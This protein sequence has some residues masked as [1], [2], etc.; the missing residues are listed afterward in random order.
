MKETELTEFLATREDLPKCFGC[1]QE[2]PIGLKLSFQWDGQTATAEFSPGELHQGWPGLVHGGIISCLLDEAMAYAT[3]FQGLTCL[4]AKMWAKLKHPVPL[5]EPLAI[6]ATMT[7]K[8]R[9]LVETKATITL[10]DGTLAVEGAATMYIL[11]HGKGGKW[12]RP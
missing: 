12:K 4:T 3:V 9:R 6:A 1:G 7:K 10:K 11:N 8:T 5:G 2:N